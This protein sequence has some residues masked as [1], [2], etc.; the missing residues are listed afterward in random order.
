MKTEEE[1]EVYK[2]A[3][4]DYRKSLIFGRKKFNT[5][6][7]FCDYF[8]YSFSY[9][10]LNDL[11]DLP[12]L[13]TLTPKKRYNPLPIYWFEPGRLLPRIKLL[14]KAIRICQKSI[15]LKNQLK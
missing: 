8:F 6:R 15:H 7:G 4:K 9:S 11:D 13:K 14:K 12:V 1:L 3:L 10:I 2:K 5:K